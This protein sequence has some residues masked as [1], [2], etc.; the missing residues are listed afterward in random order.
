MLL[1][2]FGTPDRNHPHASSASCPHRSLVDRHD[3]FCI[4]RDRDH[5]FGPSISRRSRRHRPSPQTGKK[6]SVH[7]TG[8]LDDGG[9]PGKKFDSS[10]D[11]G[12][13][14]SFTLGIGQVIGGWDQGVATMKVGG[15]RTLIIP[16]D[17][18]YGARGA[19]G[20]IPRTPRSSSTSN[21]SA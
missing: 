1:G 11:R 2:P 15:K 12:Q 7:Y 8:W 10:R 14:F 18:G 4:R 16:S 19:G 20:L 13:P 5:A 6:V 17:L 21:C 3:R 9:K